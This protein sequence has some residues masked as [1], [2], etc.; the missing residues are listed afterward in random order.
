MSLHVLQFAD[1][2]DQKQLQKDKLDQHLGIVVDLND[3][4]HLCIKLEDLQLNK[5]YLKIVIYSMGSKKEIMW[6][7]YDIKKKKFEWEAGCKYTKLALLTKFLKKWHQT[8]FEMVANVVKDRINIAV[9]EIIGNTDYLTQEEYKYVKYISSYLHKKITYAQLEENI[10][11]EKLDD[12]INKLDLNIKLNKY[13]DLDIEYERELEVDD[14]KKYI[15]QIDLKIKEYEDKSNRADLDTDILHLIIGKE[16]LIQEVIN[17]FHKDVQT[18]PYTYNSFYNA[19]Q[20]CLS[21]EDCKKSGYY[22]DVC[23]IYGFIENDEKLV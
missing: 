18:G 8:G 21:E 1:S 9:N 10:D 16:D 20:E 22:P 23:D 19:L 6:G 3:P 7:I 17:N 15:K 14:L 4:F 5:N 12:V 13:E 2:V 11:L